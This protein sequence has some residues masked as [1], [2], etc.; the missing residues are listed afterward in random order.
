PTL[1]PEPDAPVEPLAGGCF[2]G[3]IHGPGVSRLVWWA[4]SGRRGLPIAFYVATR[5]RA[6][7]VSDAE[8]VQRLCGHA[9]ALNFTRRTGGVRTMTARTIEVP[10]AGGLLVEERSADTPYF[11][12]PGAHYAAFETLD[13]LASVTDRLL[14]DDRRRRQMAADAH[15]WASRYYAGDYFWTGILSRLWG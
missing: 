14:S 4:E 5:T 1:L 13:D 2:I 6:E 15:A 11:L 8:Y 7:Q 9:F 12:V 3:S 10:I